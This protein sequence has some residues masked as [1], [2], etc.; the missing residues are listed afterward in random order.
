MNGEAVTSL[1]GTPT[2]KKKREETRVRKI[3][4]LVHPE[5]KNLEIGHHGVAHLRQDVRAR[6]A[7]EA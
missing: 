3:E 1:K 5:R 7:I 4:A 2:F 6:G